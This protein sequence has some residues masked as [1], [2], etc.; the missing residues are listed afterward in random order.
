M[1]WYQ[2][3]LKNIQNAHGI[4]FAVCVNITVFFS[5]MES[6][7]GSFN[8]QTNTGKRFSCAKRSFFAFKT[9]WEQRHS[10]RKCPFQ[11]RKVKLDQDTRFAFHFSARVERALV[12]YGP[13]LKLLK[14]SNENDIRL[15]IA[16]TKYGVQLLS[17]FYCISRPLVLLQKMKQSWGIPAFHEVKYTQIVLDMFHSLKLLRT[18][19]EVRESKHGALK[20]LLS[21]MK[22]LQS[23]KFFGIK[24]EHSPVRFKT[25]KVDGVPQIVKDSQPTSRDIIRFMHLYAD[26]NLQFLPYILKQCTHSWSPLAVLTI[27]PVT[28]IEC[29]TGKTVGG[30]LVLDDH[31][32]E[33]IASSEK[34]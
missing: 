28:L 23:Y 21:N 6:V 27:D 4:R 9:N 29:V 33:R 17:M 10:G 11:L 16:D 18:M 13:L 8:D 20:F 26:Y 25:Q 15:W 30:K 7:L 34:P 2:R 14:A 22:D 12:S 19:K 31:A 24:L 1:P 5:D 32:I 3:R